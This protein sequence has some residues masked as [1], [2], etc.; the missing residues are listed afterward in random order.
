V[1]ELDQIITRED[2]VSFIKALASDY[3]NSPDKWEN[4]TIDRYLEALAAWVEDM[5]GYYRN[6][7][8]T[9]PV[10]IDWKAFANMLMAAK[11]YE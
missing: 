11:M 3:I 8:E 7:G 10:D 9:V 2:F 4:S 5:D 6:M 1:Y